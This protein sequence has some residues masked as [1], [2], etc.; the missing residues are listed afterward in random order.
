MNTS[1]THRHFETETG[2]RGILRGDL[3][4]YTSGMVRVEATLLSRHDDGT[5]YR[6]MRFD[7]SYHPV[8]DQP[9]EVVVWLLG[10]YSSDLFRWSTPEGMSGCDLLNA[11]VAAADSTPFQPYIREMFGEPLNV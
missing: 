5:L 6:S 2:E 1:V 9:G 3:Q 11:A 7:A 4:V 10:A 8:T